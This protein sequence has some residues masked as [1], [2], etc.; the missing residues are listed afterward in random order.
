MNDYIVAALI[1]LNF[2]FGFK[3]LMVPGFRLRLWWKKTKPEFDAPEAEIKKKDTQTKELFGVTH[4]G[5]KAVAWSM[6]IAFLMMCWT[7][8]LWTSIQAFGGPTGFCSAYL[9]NNSAEIDTDT[10]VEV[11]DP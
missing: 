1:V 9:G 4:G 10:T 5:T 2:W 11:D 3:Y 6:M 7:L 8:G